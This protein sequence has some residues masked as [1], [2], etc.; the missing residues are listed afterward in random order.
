MYVPH[1]N[2]A[3]VTKSSI[4]VESEIPLSVA[5]P[6][7]SPAARAHCR[8]TALEICSAHNFSGKSTSGGII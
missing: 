7:V 2:G 5:I 8:L 6:V 3:T 1:C 4:V